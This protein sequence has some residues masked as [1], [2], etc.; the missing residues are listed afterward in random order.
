M[1][2][3]YQNA[4]MQPI[5]KTTFIDEDILERQHIQSALK[6]NIGIVAPECLV[7]AEEFSEWEDSRRRLDLLA[8]DKNANLV[9]IEL[10]RTDTGKH[11]ELQALRYAAMVSALT[12]KK[13]IDI[14]QNFLYAN[15]IDEDAET[16]LLA[17]LNW[18]F[19]QEE[20]FA[21]N[22]RIILVSSDFSKELTTTIMWLNDYGLDIRCVSMV[23]YKNEDQIFVDVKQVLPLP[24]AEEYQIKLRKKSEEK[25]QAA[26][27][28]RDYTRYEFRGEELNKRKLVLA[29]IHTW[30]KENQP[31]E[32]DALLEVFPQELHS[33]GLFVPI[34]KAREIYERQNIARH[35]LN[36][37]ELL[38]FGSSMYAI[39]NQWE[40]GSIE[41]FIAHAKKI[42]F[43][44]EAII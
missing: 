38:V 17:F 32:L 9:V 40:K 29:V 26:Q 14:Y 20:E 30:V 41:T 7:I 33:G 25:R 42:G 18:E 6:K 5:Q 1:I 16:N 31:Q 37:D 43:E 21:L 19:P 10:K 44:V 23:P 35:F 8:I 36:E 12:Y 27:S 3:T 39:S 15:N 22:V 4:K 11:M 34:E 13:V 28:S 24:E 2:Y